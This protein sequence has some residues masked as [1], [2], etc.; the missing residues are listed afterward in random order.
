MAIQRDVTGQKWC[1][2]RKRE[3]P[4]PKYGG[5]AINRR[6]S[7][8]ILG[9]RDPKSDGSWVWDCGVDAYAAIKVFFSAEGILAFPT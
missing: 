5:R 8:S 3:I 7:S 6:Y 1:Q 4:Q 9:G 2:S